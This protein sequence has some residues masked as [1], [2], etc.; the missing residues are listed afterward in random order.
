MTKPTYSELEAENL[1]VRGLLQRLEWA[2]SSYGDPCCPEC[3]GEHGTH[4]PVCELYELLKA[5]AESADIGKLDSADKS[6]VEMGKE[7]SVAEEITNA[8]WTKMKSGSAET[9]G[10]KA[11]PEW[12][13]VENMCRERGV[14]SL[15]GGI[16]AARIE[17]V[18]PKCF[19]LT[20]EVQG[21]DRCKCATHPGCRQPISTAR[22]LLS[23]ATSDQ[24]MYMA[25]QAM[26]TQ[27]RMHPMRRAAHGRRARVQAAPE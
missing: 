11:A 18:C 1:R 6:G 13:Y 9:G 19:M 15:G 20:R 14:C 2:G 17:D 21:F 10:E 22:I 12:K 25:P 5:G 8:G 3:W 26:A 16:T 7:K 23:V 4:K 27:G 24:A